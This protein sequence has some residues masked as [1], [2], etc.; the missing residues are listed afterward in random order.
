MLI[1]TTCTNPAN[2]VYQEGE[3]VWKNPKYDPEN[4]KSKEFFTQK[5]LMG[6]LGEI[7]STTFQKYRDYENTMTQTGS[8]YVNGVAN[9]A[10]FERGRV[11]TSI[12]DTYITQDNIMS[13]MHDDVRGF[14]TSSTF[15]AQLSEYLDM[16]GSDGNF[17]KNLKID[18]DGPNGVPDG[19]VDEFDYDMVGK[20]KERIIDAIINKSSNYG[21]KYE[22]SR[23]ILADWL[24]M[25]TEEKFYGKVEKPGG[26]H[27]T[28]EERR[29][30]RQIAGENPDAFVAR[31]GIM[32]VLNS[33]SIYWNEELNKWEENSDVSGEDLKKKYKAS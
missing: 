3:W 32:S 1:S 23:D 13:M 30:M 22:T 10:N 2:I 27:Y 17:Y 31:G 16:L 9:A 29:E 5:D 8:A 6:S 14:G 18:V 4:P 21:Y 7:E 12:A 25:H 28:I 20:D 26:G 19:I 15:K 24:T 33:L 11:K